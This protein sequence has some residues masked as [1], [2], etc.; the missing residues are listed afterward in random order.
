MAA[1]A[2]CQH[3]LTACKQSHLPSC[4]NSIRGLA[5]ASFMYM[6]EILLAFTVLALQSLESC[7]QKLSEGRSLQQFQVQ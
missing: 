4:F 5:R 7:C 3:M 2:S 6:K 1:S